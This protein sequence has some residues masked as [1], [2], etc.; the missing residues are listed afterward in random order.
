MA[1]EIQTEAAHVT[2]AEAAQTNVLLARLAREPIATADQATSVLAST[3]RLKRPAPEKWIRGRIATLLNHYFVSL[4]PD[5]MMAEIA[6]DWIAELLGLPAWAIQNAARWW[7]SAD[8]TEAA[9]RRKPMPGDIAARARHE[10]GAI[11]LAEGQANRFNA[12][13]VV[14][15]PPREDPPAEDRASAD[16]VTR[17]MEERG[18]RPRKFGGGK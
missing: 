1:R 11:R 9:R 16:A 8:N 3:A 10:M 14:A 4:V 18:F 12:A 13:Q 2:P 15:T 5:A 17:I 6:N 7:M